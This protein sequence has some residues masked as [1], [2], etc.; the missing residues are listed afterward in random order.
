MLMCVYIYVLGTKTLHM[1]YIYKLCFLLF[2]FSSTFY[3]LCLSPI[4]LDPPLQR[5]WSRQVG[6]IIMYSQPNMVYSE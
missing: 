5:A 6:V 3:L 4:H 2:D 1:L